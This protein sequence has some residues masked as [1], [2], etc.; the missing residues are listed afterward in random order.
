MDEILSYYKLLSKLLD[1]TFRMCPRFQGFS[2]GNKI[3]NLYKKGAHTRYHI[4]R[5]KDPSPD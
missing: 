3:E 5:N 1:E 4:A 2:P